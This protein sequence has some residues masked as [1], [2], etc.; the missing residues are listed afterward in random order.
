MDV[1]FYVSELLELHGD[2]SVPGLGH[3]VRARISGYYNEAEQ[4]F[5]PPRYEVRFE[6]NLID[7]DDI[8]IKHIADKKNISL[9]SSEYFIEKYIGNLKQEAL[10]HEVQMA[11]AGVFYTEDDQ[12][13][14]RPADNLVSDKAFYGMP[15]VKINKLNPEPVA[16][17]TSSP[18]TP[19]S[20]EASETDDVDPVNEDEEVY[21]EEP[22]SNRLLRNWLIVFGVIVALALAVFG[23]QRYNPAAFDKLRNWNTAKTA[24][25]IKAESRQATADTT[26]ADTVAKTDSAAKNTTPVT[27][28]VTNTFAPGSTRVEIIIEACNT[29]K[30]ANAVIER[31]KAK[32]VNAHIVTDAPGKLLKL[33]AGTYSNRDSAKVVMNALIAEKKIYRD[34]Y[35]LEIKQK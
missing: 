35:P 19:Y 34:S 20:P 7:E 28:T 10:N 6:P 2:V 3:L 25:V 32:G 14:F 30:K 24:P 1:G 8:L 17:T 15:P 4:A 22:R 26:K 12:L 18:E 23:L 29:L 27:P 21:D 13:N 31:Y 33:S 11:G 5:Y 9:E 16:E